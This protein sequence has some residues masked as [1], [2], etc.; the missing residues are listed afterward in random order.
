MIV[1]GKVPDVLSD[2]T[3]YSL[4]MG[5]LIAGTKYRGDFEKRLKGVIAELKK[6]PGAILFIDEIHTVIGA[7]AASGGVMDA[8]NL[9]KPVLTNGELR[10]IGSTTYQEYR[11]IFEK[12]HALAR[13]FQKI[14]VVE[15]SV[16]ETIDILM[17]LKPRFEQHHGIT[18]HARRD[19]RRGRTRRAPHQ[20]PPH[21]RQGH[22]RGR[23]GGRAPAAQAGERTRAGGRREAHR[24]RGRAHGAH[25]GQERVGAPTR[26][27]CATSSAI[28]SW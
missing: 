1:E 25:P 6:Q 4:D 17:G 11:G 15:P 28:S 3:I 16:S 5:S 2:C 24:G 18:L 20:R 12:D 9:I 21:A 23:R 27:C 13:R 22:R 7:G 10:C 26:K 8:S 19:P 14:D